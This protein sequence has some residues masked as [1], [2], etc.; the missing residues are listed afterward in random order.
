MTRMPLVSRLCAVLGAFGM[1]T[2]IALAPSAA[3]AHAGHHHHAAPVETR[4]ELSK[5]ASAGEPTVQELRSGDIATPQAQHDPGCGE[6]GCCGNGH[7]A[8]CVTALAPVSL[9]EF[10]PLVK[11]LR[12]TSDA[13]VPPG[14]GTSGP[15]RPPKSFV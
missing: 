9:A 10:N 4:A 15:P 12:A 11:S 7:C 6:R 3:L 13:A 8:G 1:L 14:L 5:P 2:L